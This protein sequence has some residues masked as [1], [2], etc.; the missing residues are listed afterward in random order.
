MKNRASANKMTI[1]FALSGVVSPILFAI[2]V[3][4]GATFYPGYSHTSQAISE[5]GGVGATNPLIQNVNFVIVG[6]LTSVFAVG[7]HRGISEGKGSKLGPTLIGIFGAITI[8]QGFLPCDRGCDFVTLVGTLHNVT[9][10]SSFLAMSVG[11]YTMSRR[12]AN[13]VN[14]KSLRGYSRLTAVVGFLALVAWI[15]ISKVAGVASLNG[16]LQRIMIAVLLLWIEVAAIRLF[17]LSRQS[18][19]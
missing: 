19:E 14:W 7:L 11:V 10:L 9:G 13:D 2:L 17:Q 4:V 6:L 5:L 3:F 1:L 8:V 12:M 15:G 18:S 16:V